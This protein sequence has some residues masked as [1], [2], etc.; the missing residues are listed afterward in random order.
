MATVLHFDDPLV[1]VKFVEAAKAGETEFLLKRAKEKMD[2]NDSGYILN[3]LAE[4]TEQYKGTSVWIPDSPI[5]N[6][7]TCSIMLHIGHS[8][9]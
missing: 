2:P 4:L 5:K 8:G 7:P 1:L 9:A 3:I 6:P